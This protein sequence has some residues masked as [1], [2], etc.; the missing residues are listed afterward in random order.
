MKSDIVMNTDASRSKQGR[1]RW[2][3]WMPWIS[4]KTLAVVFKTPEIYIF[5]LCTLVSYLVCRF[6][7]IPITESSPLDANYNPLQP[8]V[9]YIYVTLV[10]TFL[11]IAIGILQNRSQGYVLSTK[12][13]L[14]AIATDCCELV[15][16]MRNHTPSLHGAQLEVQLFPDRFRASLV[17][18]NGYRDE[19]VLF[20][21]TSIVDPRT[22]PEKDSLYNLKAK[23]DEVVDSFVNSIRHAINTNTEITTSEKPE[24]VLRLV[25]E[26]RARAYSLLNTEPEYL[27]PVT[28]DTIMFALY[29][30][31]VVLP[32]TVWSILAFLWGT[33]AAFSF[34]IILVGFLEGSRSRN[35]F[36]EIVLARGNEWYEE[37]WYGYMVKLWYESKK[38]TL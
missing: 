1:N 16:K 9:P 5:M 8:Q 30:L 13:T 33:L 36:E 7:S 14:N 22:I 19:V 12:Q 26:I 2:P 31:F 37:K 23:P 20:Q 27:Y 28:S 34:V 4:W 25:T 6:F 11:T 3:L 29:S 18:S 35:A 24:E 15:K 17:A 32:V 38:D 21:W 10:F